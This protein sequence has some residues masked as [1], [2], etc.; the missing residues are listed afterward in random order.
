MNI[1]CGSTEKRCIFFQKLHSNTCRS[2]TLRT[3]LA[4]AC[5][6]SVCQ[7]GNLQVFYLFL[8][9][10][11]GKTGCTAT[12]R[13]GIAKSFYS[14]RY[15]SKSGQGILV[16]ELLQKA[17]HSILLSHKPFPFLVS[18]T[19]KLPGGIFCVP[20][21]YPVHVLMCTKVPKLSSFTP[22]SI[23]ILHLIAE[24]IVLTALFLIWHLVNCL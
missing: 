14:F 13:G 10:P 15:N 7:S 5:I 19:S 6:M 23:I 20:R 12:S 18:L 17:Y 4:W 16:A 1:A 3:D 22:V 2:N 11:I 8:R 24:D 9:K 21:A